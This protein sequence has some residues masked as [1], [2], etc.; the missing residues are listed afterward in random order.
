MKKPETKLRN[1]HRCGRPA[2][3]RCIS[4]AR[5][6]EQLWGNPRARQGIV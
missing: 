1:R 2:S 4:P 3:D 5:L 6:D